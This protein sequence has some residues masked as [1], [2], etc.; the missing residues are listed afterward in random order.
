MSVILANM[1]AYHKPSTIPSIATFVEHRL[2][3]R[4]IETKIASRIGKAIFS[5]V[6]CAKNRTL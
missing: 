3:V 2:S 1:I 6:L 5:I 4:I